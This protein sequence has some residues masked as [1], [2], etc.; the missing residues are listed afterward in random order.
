MK[1]R[2]KGFTLIE[3]LVVIAIIGLLSS[4]VLASLNSARERARDAARF[5]DLRTIVHALELAKVSGTELP[6]T[7]YII[8]G[9]DTTAAFANILAPYLP[10][11]PEEKYHD[12]NNTSYDYR[13]CNVTGSASVCHPDNDPNTYAL[14]FR[15]ETLPLGS[16]A[17]NI[18]CMTSQGLEARQSSYCVQR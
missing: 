7:N 15:T 5:S 16:S 10:Q 3:L 1:I 8:A 9:Q 2:H 4:V 14:R 13:Y 11:I 18:I 17:G 6:T 12:P